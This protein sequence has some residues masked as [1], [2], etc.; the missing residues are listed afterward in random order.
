MLGMVANTMGFLGKLQEK[1]LGQASAA[2]KCERCGKQASKEITRQE[3]GKMSLCAN[4]YVITYLAIMVQ[5]RILDVTLFNSAFSARETGRFR[6]AL[7][8]FQTIT[9][10]IEKLIL[11]CETKMTSITANDQER[12]SARTLLLDFL[13]VYRYVHLKAGQCAFETSQIAEHN[14]DAA[15]DIV[16]IEHLIKAIQNRLPYKYLDKKSEIKPGTKKDEVP[17]LE[18][19]TPVILLRTIGIPPAVNFESFKLELDNKAQEIDDAI[20]MANLPR[21][22]NDLIF[23]AE[24]E[25]TLGKS[26]LHL[27]S[28]PKQ[29]VFGGTEDESARKAGLANLAANAFFLGAE[30]LDLARE[31]I[32]RLPITE[33]TFKFRVAYG[34]VLFDLGMCFFKQKQYENAIGQFEKALRIY[35]GKDKWP[36]PRNAELGIADC[37][38]YLGQAEAASHK[39]KQARDH[40][41]TSLKIS[42]KLDIRD[43]VQRARAL[44]EEIGKQH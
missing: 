3:G 42:T 38:L 6:D 14:F 35:S 44:L 25:I 12:R 9:K 11:E 5:K 31:H 20:L 43:N 16:A 30:V 34:T 22:Q 37:Y 2:K 15:A 33:E 29:G 17:W 41:E 36:S 7:V 27:G 10:N 19:K 13:D 18:M 4:C 39:S 24:C 28:Y 40:L 26:L 32:E 23:S 1:S 21:Y 8:S